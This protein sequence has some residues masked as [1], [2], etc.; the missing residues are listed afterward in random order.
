MEFKDR[1]RALRLDAGVTQNEMAKRLGLT[2]RAVGA[3]ESGRAKPGIDKLQEIADY[4]GVSPHWLLDGSDGGSTDLSPDEVELLACYR[5]T[6]ERG[7][8]SIIDTA[9]RERGATGPV[10]SRVR[11]TA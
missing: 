2:G 1:V 9:R 7:R 5:S 8:A 11:R 4:F 6:D 10:A 3:W